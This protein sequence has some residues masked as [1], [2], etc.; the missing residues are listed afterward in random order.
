[1][2]GDIITD[3]LRGMQSLAVNLL[4]FSVEKEW[5]V[6]SPKLRQLSGQED[7]NRS[8][9]YCSFPNKGVRFHP[10]IIFRIVRADFVILI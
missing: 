5:V 6:L 9:C 10:H 7:M 1:M 2:E 3:Y 8:Y 4:P